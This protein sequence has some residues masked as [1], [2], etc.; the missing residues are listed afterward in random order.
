[1]YEYVCLW[2]IWF[3]VGVNLTLSDSYALT[4]LLGNPKQH[5]AH[6]LL[7]P[8]DVLQMDFCFSVQAE[9]HQWVSQF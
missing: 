8:F 2:I 1:M 4:I 7:I 6:I 3:L 9:S 5:A